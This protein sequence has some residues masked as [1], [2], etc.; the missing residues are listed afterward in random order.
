[1][2]DKKKKEESK[3]F[4]TENDGEEEAERELDWGDIQ[5]LKT[6]SYLT[7]EEGRT[8]IKITGKPRIHTF[9]NEDG[10]S[11][12]RMIIPTEKGEYAV[13]IQ[14]AKEIGKY[15][16]GGLNPVIVGRTGTGKKDTRYMVFPA[17][18]TA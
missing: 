7:F 18:G 17:T 10:T 16:S 15:S 11:R 3:A 14:L 9:R 6:S 13:S 2:V 8:Q 1:M 12:D 4:G 5:N